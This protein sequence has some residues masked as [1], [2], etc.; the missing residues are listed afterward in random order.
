MSV[1]H[2]LPA[3]EVLRCYCFVT[4][5]AS[6]SVHSKAELRIGSAWTLRWVRPLTFAESDHMIDLCS[7]IVLAFR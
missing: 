2:S 4:Q 3:G 6:Q 7:A 5:V 1:V